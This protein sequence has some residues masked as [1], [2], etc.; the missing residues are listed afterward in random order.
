MSLPAPCLAAALWPLGSGDTSSSPCPSAAEGQWPAAAPV[1]VASSSLLGF[2][3]FQH[4]CSSF[5][6]WTLLL[7]SLA[8]PCLPDWILILLVLLLSFSTFF[9]RENSGQGPEMALAIRSYVTLDKCCNSSKTWFLFLQ[10]GV[11]SST[12]EACCVVIS[13]GSGSEWKSLRLEW[14]AAA[15]SPAEPGSPAPL[16]NPAAGAWPGKGLGT[17]LLGAVCEDRHFPRPCLA[18]P[19]PGL[20]V[21]LGPGT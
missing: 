13:L 10:S 16:H 1:W 2:Q 17:W 6:V 21:G 5:P 19:F 11:N 20:W 9:C 15:I 3:L 8:W 4:C 14:K 18:L 12:Q 7:N